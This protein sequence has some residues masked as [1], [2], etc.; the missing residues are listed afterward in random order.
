MQWPTCL[1]RS[2]EKTGE[3]DE[4]HDSKLDCSGALS[5][6][7][8]WL[9]QG[10]KRRYGVE[11]WTPEGMNIY[12]QAYKD[13]IKRAIIVRSTLIIKFKPPRA[14]KPDT[15]NY[16]PGMSG[17]GI[18]SPTEVSCS[19]SL[20]PLLEAL[21][22]SEA[23]RNFDAQ[24]A[25]HSAAAS[26]VQC[27]EL[28]DPIHMWESK[29]TRNFASNHHDQGT[30]AAAQFPTSQVFSAERVV[31]ESGGL[32]TSRVGNLAVGTLHNFILEGGS[33]EFEIESPK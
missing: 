9:V 21:Y 12:R 18:S 30:A 23:A 16:T 1:Q 27:W 22:T 4:T 17:R 10:R 26:S 8:N 25:I 20:N 19:P 13:I 31:R 24:G 7:G 14:S 3:F 5:E 32:T 29:Q 15:P 28:G 11:H 6:A 33:S 2:C